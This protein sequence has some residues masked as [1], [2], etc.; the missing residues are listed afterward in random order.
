MVA[1][2]VQRHCSLLLNCFR[3]DKTHPR[4]LDGLAA[5]LRIG[6]IVLVGLDVGLNELR[7]H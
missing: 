1:N 7:R 5:C 4:S 2:P 6:G 3:W